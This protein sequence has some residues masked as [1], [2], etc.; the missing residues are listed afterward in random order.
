MC[1]E[2]VENHRS[3][4]SMFCVDDS[5]L[6]KSTLASKKSAI[7]AKMPMAVSKELHACH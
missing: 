2:K 3:A 1:L 7:A 5:G 6:K 4:I